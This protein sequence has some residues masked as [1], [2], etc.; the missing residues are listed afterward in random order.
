MVKAAWIGLGNMGAPLARHL[1]KKVSA[2]KVFDRLPAACQK[3]TANTKNVTQAAS[4]ADAAKDSDFIFICLPTSNHVKD[5][6]KDLCLHKGQTIVD[7]TSGNPVMSQELAKEARRSGVEYV[8][9]AVSGGPRGAVAGSVAGM[10]G[11]SDVAVRKVLPL[12]DAFC[13]KVVHVGGVGAGHAVKAVNNTLN[14]GNFMLATE[15]LLALQRMQVKPGA[16]LEAINISSGRS[17]QSISVIPKTVLTRKFDYGFQLALM[18]KDVE[19]G[20]SIAAN[21]Y[22]QSDEGLFAAVQKQMRAALAKE[23]PNADYTQMAKSL[24]S[25]AGVG[26]LKLDDG[27]SMSEI[28]TVLTRQQPIKLLVLDMAGTTVNEGGAVYEVLRRSMQ[29]AGITVTENEID[30]WHGAQ[31]IEVI[32]HFARREFF[33]G[34]REGLSATEEAKL[35]QVMKKVDEVFVD[36]LAEVYFSPGS[37]ISLISPSLPEYLNKLRSFGCKVA[38]NTGYPRKLQR[39]IIDHLHMNEFI[40]HFISAQDVPCGRPSPFMIHRLMEHLDVQNV[41]QVAK[42]G[43]TIR[44]IQE[45]VNA[46]CSLTIGVLSGADKQTDLQQAGAQLIVSNITDV[47]YDVFQKGV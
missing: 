39:G 46:G 24:E 41:K 15:G 7:I 35:E 5:V 42:A 36:Q 31:K 47:P 45:G 9:C 44:D 25:F 16:A 28:Q 11:G 26:E 32:E 40:D 34:K 30:P 29:Q 19:I 37:T 33:G 4:V 20:A 23:G 43:D 6:L 2:L 18:A 12:L 8:D 22:G 21:I 3:A 1:A 38:L 10:V 13:A 14:T 27:A 17:Q